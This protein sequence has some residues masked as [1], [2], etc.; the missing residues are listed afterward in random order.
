MATEIELKVHVKNFEVL[1]LL[2]LEKAN[3][4]YSFEKDD[5]YW[6]PQEYPPSDQLRGT[7]PLSGLRIRRESRIFPDETAESLTLVTYKTKEV[8][9]GVEINDEREFSVDPA[10]LFEELLK[11]M[12]FK[13][14]ISKHKQGWAFSREGIGAE[15][16]EVKGLGWFLELE[17]I[18]DEIPDGERRE[19]TLAKGRKRLLDLLD[20]FGIERGAIESRF[21]S[22]ML[23]K[24]GMCGII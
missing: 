3:Y 19:E 1:R 9:D 17:I 14:G 12:G 23:G 6:F 20:S 24:S 8:R 10:P 22:E 7:L 18:V 21:Y 2:L 16:L 11:R 4:H 13:P 15:L 5:N